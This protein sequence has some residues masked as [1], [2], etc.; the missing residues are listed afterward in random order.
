[1]VLEIWS[2][3]DN[4]LLFWTVF[5]PFIGGYGPRK[6]KFWKNGKDTWRYYHFTN[7]YHKRQPYGMWFLRYGVQRAE[8]FVILDC[9]LLFYPPPLPPFP[10]LTTQKIKILKKWKKIPGDVIILH[11]CTVNDNHMMYGSWDMKRDGQNFL[12]F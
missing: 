5:C 3:T 11:M 6:L 9:F 8:F 10:L 1:M 12:S 2:T 4:F 7:V